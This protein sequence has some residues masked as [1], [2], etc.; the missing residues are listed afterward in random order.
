MTVIFI[1]LIMGVVGLVFGVILALA[2]QK[3]AVELNPLIHL[4]EEALPKGQCGAC[5]FAGC[6]AYAE[7]VVTDPKVPPNL[8]T[9]GK[10]AVAQK[11]AE[12][13]DKKAATVEARVA[14][15][16]CG[17]PIGIAKVKYNYSGI[18]D[19]VAASILHL[20]PK[21]CQWGCI[22]FGTCVRHCPFGAI[23]L[24]QDSLP[25][26]DTRLCTGCGKCV[27]SCP[28]KIIEMIPCDAP[29]TV[30][31]GSKDPGA[32]ARKHCPVACLGCGLCAKNCP[33]GAIAIEHHLAV[34]N[35]EICATCAEPVCA[36][37][38][39]TGAIRAKSSGEVQQ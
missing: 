37:K 18:N 2:N 22:G 38:C 32:A 4:V 33:H 13:T 17:N 11:V 25:E 1:I 8:C 27:N 9:P 21:D 31:C 23:K 14:F 7:A 20:G 10:A 5:G 24:N 36:S 3:L 39:P 26:I 30:A 6:Q 28:K 15:V 35:P 29:V 16:K 34:V 19:C 12:L